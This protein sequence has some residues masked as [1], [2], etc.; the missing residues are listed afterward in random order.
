MGLSAF[1]FNKLSKSEPKPV[2]GSIY[3]FKVKSLDGKEIDFSQYKGKNY[4]ISLASE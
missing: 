2:T 4:M 1:L 3:D